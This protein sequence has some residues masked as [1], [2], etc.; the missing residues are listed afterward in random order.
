M[1][2]KHRLIT[3]RQ[4]IILGILSGCIL[5]LIGACLV[6]SRSGH[7]TFTPPVT[8]KTTFSSDTRSFPS[9]ISVAGNILVTDTGKK[10]ILKGLMPADP[11]VLNR[12]GKFNQDFIK[13]MRDTGANVI[14]IPVH[15]ENWEQ[16]P[17]YL[18]RYLDPL[19]AWSGELGM[20]AIIDLHFI[21]NVETGAGEQM[22]DIHTPSK[23]FTL[24][25]WR[26]IANYF[27]DTP[28]VIFEI[29]NEP[30]SISP[31]VWRQTASEI[32]T[33]IR[34]AGANQLIVAGGV[35]FSKDISWVL[36]QPIHDKNIAYAA[37]IY[38]SH[39]SF[40]WNGWFGEVSK[41]YPVLVTEWGWLETSSDQ[42]TEYLI[43]SAASYGEP[44]LGYLDEREIGWVACWYDDQWMPA[45][46]KADFL[47]ITGY[48]NFVK[49]RLAN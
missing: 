23:D 25:F 12:K 27:K 5:F 21:G 24:A 4:N 34:T 48:G 46:F 2:N 7:L 39:T 8:H 9:Q 47:E 22:P 10:I 35:E 11:A 13:E 31:S 1:A 18:W 20:Y 26:M 45:M 41:T 37:H 3:G 28:N 33:T 29:V 16:D 40:Y 36:D 19:V 15:P 42:K 14:R 38:P 17:D 43:G 32:T 30:E 44:L 49:M 6:L